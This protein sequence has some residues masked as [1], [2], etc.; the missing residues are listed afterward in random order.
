MNLGTIIMA[1]F[2]FLLALL[3]IERSKGKKKDTVIEQQ[4][5][6]IA[7]EKVQSK[8]LEEALTVTEEVAKAK[9]EVLQEQKKEETKIEK[10]ETEKDVI[11][12]ANSIINNFNRVP[13]GGR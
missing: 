10:A 1:A 11:N 12:L 13:D 9:E 4:K 2:A 8:V 3:G 7:K 6:E 5:Q